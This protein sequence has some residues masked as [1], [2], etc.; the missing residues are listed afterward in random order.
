MADDLLEVTEF[1]LFP[2]DFC[3]ESGHVRLRTLLGS[4]VAITVWHPARQHG[5][6]C[7]FMF[8]GAGAHASDSRYA[9]DAMAMFCRA[10]KDEGTRPQDYQVKLFGGGMTPVP[11]HEAVRPS[12]SAGCRNV[13]EA[14]SMLR[15]RGFHIYAEDV[16]GA[17]YR[18]VLFDLWSG[19][20]WLKRTDV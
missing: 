2:G 11:C 10:L 7:H 15:E 20:T 12:L 18:K 16:G 1:T 3:F 19:D 13:A 17:G 5:G 6:M 4:C 8:P 9:R 14:R